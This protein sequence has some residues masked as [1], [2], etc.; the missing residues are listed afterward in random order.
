MAGMQTVSRLKLEIERHR[1][2]QKTRVPR[3][4]S[5]SHIHVRFDDAPAIV[6][7]VSVKAGSMIP[8]FPRHPEM[9]DRRFISFPASGNLRYGNSRPPFVKISRLRSLFHNDG[10]SSA[11]RVWDVRDDEISHSAASS[12][13]ESSQSEGEVWQIHGAKI[14]N[15][16]AFVE[17]SSPFTI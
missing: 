4:L 7:E 5:F 1:R 13:N 11:V 8:I 14:K 10:G 9:S 2:P 17:K 12:Q 15:A 3:P 6:H 16:A